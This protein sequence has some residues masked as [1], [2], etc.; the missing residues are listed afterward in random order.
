MVDYFLD[1]PGELPGGDK[2][3]PISDTATW[4][5]LH[6]VAERLVKDCVLEK[7]QIGWQMTGKAR[8]CLCSCLF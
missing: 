8:T 1:K 6:Y 4:S 5:N 3:G 2:I 7:G